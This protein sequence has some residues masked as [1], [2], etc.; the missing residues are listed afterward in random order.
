MP[1]T[2]YTA[3]NVFAKGRRLTVSYRLERKN[4]HMKGPCSCGKTE[5]VMT[6]VIIID[7]VKEGE[8]ILSPHDLARRNAAGKV[9]NALKSGKRLCEEHLMELMEVVSRPDRTGQTFAS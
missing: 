5:G 3:R 7:K 4:P 9:Q 6:V 8:K 2:T 1:R